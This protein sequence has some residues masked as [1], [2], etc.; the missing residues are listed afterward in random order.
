MNNFR[1]TTNPQY[2]GDLLITSAEIAAVFALP[3]PYTIHSGYRMLTDTDKLVSE[4][5]VVVA[6]KDGVDRTFPSLVIA[7]KELH[8]D[9]TRI[10]WCIL[11]Q[12][13]YK[14]YTFKAKYK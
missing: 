7:A 9:R 2:N 10:K 12:E 1:K 6:T 11:N 8:I 5:L 3:A 14:G 13:P 4:G